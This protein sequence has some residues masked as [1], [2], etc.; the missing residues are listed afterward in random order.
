MKKIGGMLDINE[1]RVSQI[2]KTALGK[3]AIVLHQ[4]GVDSIHAFQD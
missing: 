3:M 4:N 2:H 1:S